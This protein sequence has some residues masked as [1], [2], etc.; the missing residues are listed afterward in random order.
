MLD[1]VGQMRVQVSLSLRILSDCQ[2]HYCSAEASRTS[3]LKTGGALEQTNA[4]S[5]FELDERL[6]KHLGSGRRGMDAELS[7]GAE[8]F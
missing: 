4:D 2:V 1:G 7:Y 5:R 8:N 6:V 3:V